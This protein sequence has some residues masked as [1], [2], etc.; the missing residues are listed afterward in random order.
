[1]YIYIL[2]QILFSYRLLKNIE[3]SSLCHIV[4][5]SWLSI[6]CTVICTCYSQPPNLSIFIVVFLYDPILVYSQRA[7]ENC[8]KIS[9]FKYTINP[10]ANGFKQI[11][12]VTLIFHL[13]GFLGPEVC[14]HSFL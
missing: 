13:F 4:G 7:L 10:I 1:M 11:L 3:Y 8:P 9:N 14:S 6:L 12:I 2:S 5:F